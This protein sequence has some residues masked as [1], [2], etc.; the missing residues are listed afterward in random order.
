MLLRPDPFAGLGGA[1]GRALTFVQ[2]LV[3]LL[4]LATARL[5]VWPSDRPQTVD[6]VV[7][8]A[9]GRG[10]RLAVAERLM[11]EGAGAEP[12]GDHERVGFRRGTGI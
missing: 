8:F 4:T 12:G 2:S 1:P 9:G 11:A 3:P 6:A 10:V 5:F 7:L